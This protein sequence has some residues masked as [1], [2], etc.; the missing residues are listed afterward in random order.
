MKDKTAKKVTL[1]IFALLTIYLFYAHFNA[2]SNYAKQLEGLNK[3]VQGK[4]IKEKITLDERYAVIGTKSIAAVLM[5]YTFVVKDKVYKGNITSFSRS[6]DDLVRDSAYYL[7][8]DPEIN[9]AYPKEDYATLEQNAPWNW[10][11]YLG[12]VMALICLAN[13]KKDKNEKTKEDA[14]Q[15]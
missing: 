7:V 13:L 3:L 15:K 10:R 12:I 6:A 14:P 4:G 8:E 1:I 5:P 11:L 9:S 2:K